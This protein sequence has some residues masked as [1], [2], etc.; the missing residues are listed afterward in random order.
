MHTS[1]TAVADYGHTQQA[2]D[3]PAPLDL[4]VTSGLAAVVRTVEFIIRARHMELGPTILVPTD[5][6]EY[7]YDAFLKFELDLALDNCKNL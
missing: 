3:V 2:I 4:A 1:C 7:V 5:A 6:N